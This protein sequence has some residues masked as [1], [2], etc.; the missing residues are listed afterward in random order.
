MSTNS[1]IIVQKYGGSSLAC[2]GTI[3]KIALLIKE[4]VTHNERICVIVSAMGKT[5]NQLF[6]LANEISKNPSRRELDMLL[7]CGERASTA[8]LAMALHELG[9]PSISFTGS[10]SGIITDNK[11]SSAT[12]L[13][14][15][16]FRVKQELEKKKVVIIA[17]FQGV[18]LEKE[19]TTLGRG[20]SD[21]TAIAM[22]AALNAQKC[23]I[24]SDVDGVYTADPRLVKSANLFVALSYKQMSN[25]ANSGAT[26]LQSQAVRFA[27]EKGILIHARQT[28]SHNLGTT[29]SAHTANKSL[30]HDVLAITHRKKVFNVVL[31]NTELV[32]SFLMS[33]SKNQVKIISTSLS[34]SKASTVFTAVFDEENFTCIPQLLAQLSPNEGERYDTIEQGQISVLVADENC[35]I[36]SLFAKALRSIKNAA[37]SIEHALV[38]GSEIQLFIK[39]GLIIAG[40]NALHKTFFGQQPSKFIEN[41]VKSSQLQ[42][43]AI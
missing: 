3:K 18:S 12:I 19:I 30:I 43:I 10:Q 26:V 22:T 7:S 5:T 14:I 24:Y 27:A 32:E 2:P 4:R 31:Y 15:N 40:L 17:G 28:G 11:H 36:N 21:T 8:L 6:S 23:E 1:Q 34:T 37:I 33:L 20:G 42:S 13:E 41:E 16:A 39:P 29:I 25:L 9:V 38:S 35:S